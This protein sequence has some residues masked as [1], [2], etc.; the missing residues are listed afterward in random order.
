[1]VCP[2]GHGPVL[3]VSPEEAAVDLLAGAVGDP[4]LLV[5]R[6]PRPKRGADLA[7]GELVRQGFLR[8]LDGEKGEGSE[9]ARMEPGVR[10]P[11]RLAPLPLV[12]GGDLS[13]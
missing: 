9:V 3:T 5:A 6:L 13:R 7:L 12:L 10:W 4:F 2:R 8:R 1:M 11:A